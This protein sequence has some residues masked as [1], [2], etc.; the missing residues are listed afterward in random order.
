MSSYRPWWASLDMRSG[1]RGR[2]GCAPLKRYDLIH[3]MVRLFR[4]CVD[5]LII[6]FIRHPGFDSRTNSLL[7]MTVVQDASSKLIITFLA[8]FRWFAERWRSYRY[9]RTAIQSSQ[10]EFSGTFYRTKQILLKNVYISIANAS[11]RKSVI[12]THCLIIHYSIPANNHIS[13]KYTKIVFSNLY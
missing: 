4:K 7:D 8:V 1:I 5:V 6:A 13:C 12:I 3:V 11:F 9:I 10:N 2:R